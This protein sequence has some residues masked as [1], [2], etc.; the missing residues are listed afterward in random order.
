MSESD[1]DD[2]GIVVSLERI[3]KDLKDAQA[4]VTK[5]IASERRARRQDDSV[6]GTLRK[7]H[8]KLVALNKELGEVAPT[9]CGHE[10][11]QTSK[12]KTCSCCS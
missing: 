5:V 10:K 4:H 6:A 2:I 3:L 8:L 1:D 7:I 11:L 12:Q 9:C